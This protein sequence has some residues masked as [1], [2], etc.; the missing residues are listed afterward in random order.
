LKFCVVE[1]DNPNLRRLPGGYE[2]WGSLRLDGST[3]KNAAIRQGKRPEK[4]I[5]RKKVLR[6]RHRGKKDS[7]ASTGKDYIRYEKG[8]RSMEG[9]KAKMG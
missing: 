2:M 5:S 9:Q 7:L 3:D 8:R 6:S 4:R 1:R